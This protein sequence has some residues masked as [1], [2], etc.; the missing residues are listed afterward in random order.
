MLGTKIDLG[1]IL[2]IIQEYISN[3]DMLVL[4]AIVMFVIWFIYRI[5]YRTRRFINKEIYNEIY[6]HFPTVKK[7]MENF[8]YRMRYLNSKLGDLESKIIELAKRA[9]R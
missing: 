2:E 9:E 3:Q 1:N 8:E 6:K 4:V 7:E 5:R